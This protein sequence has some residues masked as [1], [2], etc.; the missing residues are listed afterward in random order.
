MRHSIL[1][2]IF[3]VLAVASGVSAQQVQWIWTTAH[4]DEPI[5]LT[6]CY[7]RKTFRMLDPEMGQL[8]IAVNDR[9]Q[10]YI[11]GQHIGSANGTEATT[12]FDIS[13]NLTAGINVIALEVTNSTGS[14][15]GLAAA[16][17]VKEK[18]ETNW[19]MLP[20]G[21]SWKS[22]LQP[23]EDWIQVEHSD[24][25]WTACRIVPIN[26]TTQQ[27]QSAT[28]P[29]ATSTPAASPS[30][31]APTAASPL[32]ATPTAVN[33]LP[34]AAVASAS[35]TKTGEDK[36]K[37]P[38]TIAEGFEVNTLID[39]SIGSLIAI[40]FDE[41]G[42]L[43]ASRE[44]GGLIRVD[45]QHAEGNPDRVKPICDLIK[46]CQGILAINGNLYVT[47]HGP[48][49]LALYRLADGDRDGSL[50]Q[51][52]ALVKFSGV[53][54]EH[55]PH[56]IA[57][58]PD[59]YVYV[60]LGNATGLAS[61]SRGRS[62]YHTT[63]EADI[64]PR[65]EDPTGHAVGVK[66]PGGTI[67]RC[68]LDGTDAQVFA[69]GLRNAYDLAFDENAELFIHESD[70]ETDVGSRW[71]R[72][73][74][75]FQ[76]PS[77]AELGWRSGWAMFAAH[78]PDCVAPIALTGRGSPTG[79]V[80]YN[81]WAFPPRYRN[82]LFLGD[83]SEGRILHVALTPSGGK[84][85]AKSEVFLQ[86]RP[87]NVTD[88]TVGP[89]GALYFCTGGRG[90]SGGIFRIGWSNPPSAE[91]LNPP[92]DTLKLL[93][94]PQP[95]SAWARQTLAKL[96]TQ[97]GAEWKAILESA[98]T[99]PKLD[100]QLRVRALELMT[101]YGPAP[102]MQLLQAAAKDADPRVRVRVAR[103]LSLLKREKG[104]PELSAMLNDQDAWVRR[105]VCES[106]TRIGAT[107]TLNQIEHCLS[108][109]DRSEVFAARRLLESLPI[110]RYREAGLKSDKI[111]VVIQTS[112]AMM[113]AQPSTENAYAVLARTSELLEGFV[114][115]ADFMDLLRAVQLALTQGRVQ[116]DKVPAF[117]ERIAAEF[118]CNHA[119]I[120]TE[121]AKVLTFLRSPGTPGQ[122]AD[123]FDKSVDSLTDKVH[124][125][126]MM[127]SMANRMDPR[128]RRELLFTIEQGLAVTGC[129]G[130]YYAYL[131]GAAES[132]ARLIT[133]DEMELVLQRGNASPHALVAAFYHM[134]EKI[135]SSLAK[136]LIEI[137]QMP[138]ERTDS[139]TRKMRAGILAL[140]GASGDKE[141]IEYL[142]T[143][144][145]TEELRRN[146]VAFVL[147]Q[148]PE[149]ENWPYLVASFTHLDRETAGEVL[150]K[151]QQ[152]NRRPREGK[153]Y[154]ELI[155]LALRLKDTGASA[156]VTLLEHWT[157]KKLSPP[158][159][160]WQ[161]AVAAW[162][163]WYAEEFPDETPIATA[164]QPRANTSW[165]TTT[166]LNAL[167]TVETP[168]DL[169][170]GQRVFSTA[171]CAKCHRF[172]NIGDSMGP[173]LTT[174]AR[175]FNTTEMIEAIVHPSKTVSDQYRG[176]RII[177]LT[178]QTYSGLLTMGPDDHWIVLRSTGDRIKVAV[179]D[180]DEIED[181][182][183]S[184]M[185][186]GLVDTLSA[187]EVN[188]LIHFL[189]SDPNSRL[190][191]SPDAAE[192][193]IR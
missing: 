11:N 8:Q 36:E 190:A 66:A 153:H 46:G 186:D 58:G 77:G 83:W 25:Q 178:G 179:A 121:L 168:V 75:V 182:S 138:T 185:P 24:M 183:Q 18:S 60:V 20:T 57:L 53:I 64:V 15:A 158:N 88:L 97:M 12:R 155:E 39:K 30:A 104:E 4:A 122:Y 3:L 140:L 106:L 127:H 7:F 177:T 40:E 34:T 133:K 114:S 56:A 137:D 9:C 145:Q 5:P 52:K 189:Q 144:W 142:H 184:T 32:A 102:E 13:Q 38:Y 55:G 119:A 136:R 96:K 74:A 112:L 159:S 48:S 73:T 17:L 192:T 161:A 67:V 28:A 176:K 150:V 107:P 149:G 135:P 116:P 166:L 170:R 175:R 49:G 21:E 93:T 115:D 45:F 193:E 69:G 128:D 71:Y 80:V 187:S 154:R 54:G 171:Q 191:A 33:A 151:L 174:L 100:A 160:H 172:G 19:R 108:S 152:V 41:W 72:P 31:A 173:D 70:M 6:S 129:G 156:A 43:I 180:V 1:A 109:N 169:Q 99:N 162:K 44:D 105:V 50:E 118:P 27:P 26:R 117:A 81:H 68:R 98:V 125:A 103:T 61:S 188:D 146:D 143:V 157:Q 92:N 94:Y 164:D 79:A 87:L 120:N 181:L 85:V 10:V 84:Y 14:T 82:G 111:Q 90:T 134:P 132:V 2:A 47:G 124:I 126:M 76:V 63:Y 141:A 37:K 91:L 148:S 65:I 130:G 86:S 62:P 35:K 167:A 23:S 131:A 147:A 139:A 113:I 22:T 29:A 78:Q 59:G 110:E 89:D 165:T 16:I 101:L 42:R 163:Q 51:A 95:Q 123:Y